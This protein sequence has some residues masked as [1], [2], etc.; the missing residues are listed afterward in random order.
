MMFFLLFLSAFFCVFWLKK[1]QHRNKNAHAQLQFVVGMEIF[2]FSFSNSTKKSSYQFRAMIYILWIYLTLFLCAKKNYYYFSYI[3]AG[4]HVKHFA[5]LFL[6]FLFSL[7]AIWHFLHNNQMAIRNK[8]C[9]F[10]FSHS[11]LT[12]CFI[13]LRTYVHMYATYKEELKL[14]YSC[15]ST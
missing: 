9:A 6:L 8:L 2:I 3:V 1:W 5:D 10:V 12:A 14:K 13:L 15:W 11:P 7:C 4:T